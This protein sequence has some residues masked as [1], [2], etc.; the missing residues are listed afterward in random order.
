[1]GNCASHLAEYNVLKGIEKVIYD[2]S[3][4]QYDKVIFLRIVQKGG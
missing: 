4:M 1:M 3:E 2:Q